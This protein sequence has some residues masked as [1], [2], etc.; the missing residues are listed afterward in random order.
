[1]ERVAAGPS[2]AFAAI[3]R[4]A[5][6]AGCGVTGHVGDAESHLFAAQPLVDFAADWLR[7]HFGS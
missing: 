3:G 2:G 4:L 6:A 7:A 5:L 1:M